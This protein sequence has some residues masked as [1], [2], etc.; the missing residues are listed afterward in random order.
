MFT[1][2]VEVKPTTYADAKSMVDSI[3]RAG[4]SNT[5]GLSITAGALANYSNGI[6]VQHEENKELREILETVAQRYPD[7]SDYI[8]ESLL[9]LEKKARQTPSLG[10]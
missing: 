8:N 6:I 5:T 9:Q 7:A 3:Q 10:L 4:F 1:R 2:R